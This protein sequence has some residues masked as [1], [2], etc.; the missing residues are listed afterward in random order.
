MPCSDESKKLSPRHK[1]QPGNHSLAELRIKRKQAK[2][3][4]TQEIADQLDNLVG[5]K[6]KI[7]RV[8]P[9]KRIAVKPQGGVA[10]M[11]QVQH[12]NGPILT[13]PS[14]SKMQQSRRQRTR[15]Q[16]LTQDKFIRTTSDIADE[17]Q[18]LEATQ[19]E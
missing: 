1:P 3:D 11:Q 17:L 2:K 6:I 4:S 10:F 13:K 18:S 19:K 8:V 5:D 9:G 15:T 16:A 7:D 12:L 14:L